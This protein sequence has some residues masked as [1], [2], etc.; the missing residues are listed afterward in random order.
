[1]DKKKLLSRLKEIYLPIIQPISLSHTKSE[2]KASI[3]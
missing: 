3:Y 2:A 1:M